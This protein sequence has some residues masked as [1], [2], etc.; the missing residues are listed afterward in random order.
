MNKREDEK[1]HQR[2]IA[3]ATSHVGKD[4]NE[5]RTRLRKL[6]QIFDPT[7]IA[8]LTRQFEQ[9]MIARDNRDLVKRLEKIANTKTVITKTNDPKMRRYVNK[10]RKDKMRMLQQSKR[11]K[12]NEL[13][14]KTSCFSTW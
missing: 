6:K 4:I 12:P 14:P 11:H 2:T 8:M 7:K 13:N 1:F 9:D 5:H 3:K 10:V